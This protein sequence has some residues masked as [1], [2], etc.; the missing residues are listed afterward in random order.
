MTEITLPQ[1]LNAVKK[2][3]KAECWFRENRD[4]IIHSIVVSDKENPTVSLGNALDVMSEIPLVTLR[5]SAIPIY[6]GYE[7]SVVDPITI[8][9]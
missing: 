6:G 1:L 7:W 3:P 4:K 8:V 9:P 2:L 5:F